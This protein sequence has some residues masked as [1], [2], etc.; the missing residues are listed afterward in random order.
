MFGC[1]CSRTAPLAKRGEKPSEA[2]RLGVGAG[3]GE[4][5]PRAEPFARSTCGGL[6]LDGERGRRP[7]TKEESQPARGWHQISARDGSRMAE[8]A[9]GGLGSRQPDPK[10]FVKISVDSV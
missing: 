9:S 8:T 10:G 1:A 4:A 5:E 6:G 7:P 2:E 3:T